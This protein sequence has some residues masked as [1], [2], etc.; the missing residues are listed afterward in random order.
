MT[1]ES[2]H[3]LHENIAGDIR[4]D[5]RSVL[6]IGRE[7]DSPAFAYTIGNALKNL[8][9]LL[10]IGN[11]SAA[12][13]LND[14]SQRMIGRGGAFDDGELVDVGGK[15][16]LK[17]INADSERTQRDYTIQVGEHL[18]HENY[19]VQQVLICDKEGRFPD[20]PE[21]ARPYST[22]PVLKKLVH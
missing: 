18:G 6:C 17:V 3:E 1:S 8:P 11:I 10:M 16:P 9:E 19:A 4:R 22:V 12:Y 13:L 20:D 7:E 2:H 21:C 5:G 14:L 15:F